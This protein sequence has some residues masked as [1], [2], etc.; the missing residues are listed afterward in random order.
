MSM[1]LPMTHHFL[2]LAIFFYCTLR[3]FVDLGNNL[4]C[5]GWLAEEFGK[6]LDFAKTYSI[7]V[8]FRIALRY[9]E[10]NV[11]VFR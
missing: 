6:K 5:I 7:R 4:E 2:E 1:A 9:L 10:N 11:D 8:N 3:A